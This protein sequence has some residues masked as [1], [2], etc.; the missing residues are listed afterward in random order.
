MDTIQRLNRCEEQREILR[1]EMIMFRRAYQ[2]AEIVIDMLRKI[3]SPCEGC[4]E[5]AHLILADWD[6]ADKVYQ[7]IGNVDVWDLEKEIDEIKTRQY[8]LEK[9]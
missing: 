5:H 3:I 8:G 7:K 9:K 6:E 2:N 1:S 4:P